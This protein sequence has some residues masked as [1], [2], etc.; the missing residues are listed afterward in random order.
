M[1]VVRVNTGKGFHMW[2]CQQCPPPIKV[3]TGGVVREFSGGVGKNVNNQH[4]G[5]STNGG[6]KNVH[7]WGW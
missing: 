4:V 6:G 1:G 5:V 2:R 3:Y 7:R